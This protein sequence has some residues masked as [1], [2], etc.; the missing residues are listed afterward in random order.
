MR[1]QSALLS[2]LL[3]GTLLVLSAC[4]RCAVILDRFEVAERAELGRVGSGA[5]ADTGLHDHLRL[6]VAPDVLAELAAPLLEG[7]WLRPVAAQRLVGPQ[8]DAALEVELIPRVTELRV[9][10]DG[11]RVRALLALELVAHARLDRVGDRQRHTTQTATTLIAALE[12]Q[13][14]DAPRLVLDASDVVAQ[15]TVFAFDALEPGARDEAEALAQALL[16]D[17]LDEATETLPLLRWGALDIAGRSIALTASTLTATDDGALHVG[18]VTPF[19]P[20]G[21]MFV[22]GAGPSDGAIWWVHRDLPRAAVD[23]AVAAGS[24]PRRFDPSGRASVLG[25]RAASVSGVRIGAVE[26]S[27]AFRWWCFD[28]GDCGVERR[29]AIYPLELA[30]GRLQLAAGVVTDLD[31]AALEVTSEYRGWTETA[32]AVISGV[33]APPAMRSEGRSRLALEITGWTPSAT[34]LRLNATLR[35]DVD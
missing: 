11:A 24:V 18:F 13:Q 15:P 31:G 9:A 17:V 35:R 14:R 29:R 32:R 22:P 25:A 3:C 26:A 30:S 16:A 10:P 20:E 33:L 7:D 1:T 8:R 5:R 28:A 21:P 4:N 12:L 6:V 27:H 19:R 34:A 2:A 23:Y